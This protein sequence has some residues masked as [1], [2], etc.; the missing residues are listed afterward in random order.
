MA[1]DWKQKEGQL[2]NGEFPLRRFLGGSEH[3]A[4]FLVDK[5][6]GG[7]TQTAI[8]FMDAGSEDARDQLGRW[9]AAS[10][11]NHPNLLRILETG[12]CEIDG[13]AFL[14]A[15]L[16]Y[17]NEDLSQILPARALTIAETQQV[18]EAVLSALSYLHGQ[19]FVHGRLKPSNIFAVGETVKISSDSVRPSGKPSVLSEANSTYGAPE[20]AQAVAPP[21]D[22][23]SLGI[24]LVEAMTQHLPVPDPGQQ[25]PPVLIPQP[26]KEIIENCLQLDPAERWTVAQIGVRLRG[27]QLETD[28]RE[29]AVA[30]SA[31][32]EASALPRIAQSK[33]QS[34][35]WFYV[36]VLAV[37]VVIAAVLIARPK[38]PR[39]SSEAQ[40]TQPE[41]ASPP[42]PAKPSPAVAEPAGSGSSNMP[43]ASAPSEG[44]RS[45]GVSNERMSTR[46]TRDDVLQ[47]VMP[48]VAPGAR[49]TITG[50]VRVLVRVNVD[51]AGNVT[52]ARLQSAGPSKYFARI[53]LEAARGWKFK[54][55]VP[56]G[57]PAA[58]QWTL[59]F[60]FNR[61]GTDVVAQRTAPQR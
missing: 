44:S 4:V 39:S 27:G 16:E 33:K 54:P 24:M 6:G 51:A 52:E 36:L 49:R 42:A 29:P 12:R 8:R 28:P 48:R 45:E 50:T 41:S 20:S 14:Y 40:P 60:G 58:S 37:A 47:R 43:P 57:Q 19:G 3:N 13:R 34:A 7:Q 35:K 15:W 22:V 10:K 26:F 11:L 5:S 1:V 25:G 30:S 9:Q 53:A 31:L 23:W 2:V 18:L 56:D 46:D 32:P 38:P 59:R 17:S 55:A 61:R 21:A